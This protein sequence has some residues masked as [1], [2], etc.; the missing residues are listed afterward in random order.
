MKGAEWWA[1]DDAG[2]L[3]GL[4]EGGGVGMKK[5]V[6]RLGLIE[7]DLVGFGRLG[8]E[9]S[10]GGMARRGNRARLSGG[11]NHR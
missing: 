5:K 11:G 3:I 6:V 8:L 4:A 7:S 9:R 1:E 2:E 10:L